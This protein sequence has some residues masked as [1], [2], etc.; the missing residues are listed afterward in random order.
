MLFMLFG[1]FDVVVR[2]PRRPSDHVGRIISR[3]PLINGTWN[4]QS[5]ASPG[6]ASANGGRHYARGGIFIVRSVVDDNE[7]DRIQSLFRLQWRL[8]RLLHRQ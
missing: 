1:A 4:I 2:R 7:A 6:M 8:C 5:E 3:R